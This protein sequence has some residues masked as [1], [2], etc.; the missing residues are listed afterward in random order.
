MSVSVDLLSGP[1]A[2]RGHSAATQDG[3]HVAAGTEVRA[4]ATWAGRNYK[5]RWVRMYFLLPARA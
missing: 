1:L 4:A 2:R 3:S 5:M